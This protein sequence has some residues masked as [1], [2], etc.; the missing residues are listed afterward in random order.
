MKTKDRQVLLHLVL[1]LLVVISLFPIVFALSNSFKSLEESFNN[2]LSLIPKSPTLSNYLYVFSRLPLFKII[3]N[4]FTIAF[5]VTA[6]KIITSVLASYSLVYYDF[7]GKNFIYLVFLT[8]M[9]I[10][11][12]VT[13]IPNY[14]IV[15][16]LGLTDS[17]WGVMLPQFADVLGIFL[18][19]QSMRTI[20]KSIIEVAKIDGVGE[21]HILLDIILPILRPSM[22]S[23]AIIF[24]INSWNEY[25]WP[26]LIISS[27]DHYTLSL[28]LQ[29]FISSEG[30]TEFPIAMAVSVITMII[31]L[32][33][34]LLFQR[35]IIS[36]FISSGVK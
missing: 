8:T 31:P 20:P 1:V 24:F 14:L 23:T 25:V 12:T 6:V 27:Q 3:F 16:K 28:A 34:F 5:L 10:P 35:H 17:I 29:M 11:F 15:S 2:V 4:T 26:V 22:I 9:F 21:G 30:G 32:V 7:K 19:R 13:M 36:T 33:L 18:L